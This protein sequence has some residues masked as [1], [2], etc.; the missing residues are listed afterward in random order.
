MHRPFHGTRED[1]LY[2][3]VSVLILGS[4]GPSLR[5]KGYMLPGPHDLTARKIPNVFL[6][7]SV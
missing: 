1:N 4:C 3:I 6:P 2:N 7:E 5:K